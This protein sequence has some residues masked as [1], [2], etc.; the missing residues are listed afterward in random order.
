M[1]KRPSDAKYQYKKSFRQ[2]VAKCSKARFQLNYKKHKLCWS[3]RFIREYSRIFEKMFFHL[4]MIFSR[5]LDQIVGI[6]NLLIEIYL[7][8]R[9]MF[10][11]Y[12]MH[13]TYY[14]LSQKT[15]SSFCFEGNEINLKKIFLTSFSRIVHTLWQNIFYRQQYQCFCDI[16]H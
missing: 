7:K 10:W 12:S 6:H 11:R 15:K 1:T 4:K 16:P 2:P 14:A 8:V 5:F 13:K 9:R 3:S